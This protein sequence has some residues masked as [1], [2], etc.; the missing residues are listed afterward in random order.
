MLRS[1]IF[2]SLAGC[3]VQPTTATGA[4]PEPDN[5][6]RVAA[7]RHQLDQALREQMQEQMRATAEQPDEYEPVEQ[8]VKPIDSHWCCQ[9]VDHKT[10]SG[11]GCTAISGSLELINACAE[12]LYCSGDAAKDDGKTYCL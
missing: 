3:G 4:P 7:V 11:T 1:I 5:A 6:A 10:K 8:E 2:A 9:D 12:Y